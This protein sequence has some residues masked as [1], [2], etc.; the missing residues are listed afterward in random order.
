MSVV[1]LML[2]RGDPDQFVFGPLIFLPKN[3]PR[4][5]ARFLPKKQTPAHTH[6]PYSPHPTGRN[7][8]FFLLIRADAWLP[9]NGRRSNKLRYPVLR[10]Y[11]PYQE[12]FQ[13]E[14]GSRVSWFSVRLR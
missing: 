8:I 3:S 13:K 9:F 4:V 12:C 10:G 7:A 1:S 2:V 5:V 11:I 6:G 14:D